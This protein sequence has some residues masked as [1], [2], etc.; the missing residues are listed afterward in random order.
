MAPASDVRKAVDEDIKAAVA[1]KIQ[2]DP[3]LSPEMALKQV[4]EAMLKSNPFIPPQGCPVNDLPSELL[5]HIFYVGTKIQ[6]D[7]MA[8]GEKEDDDYFHDNELDVA[9]DWTDDESEAMDVDKPDR[10][11]GADED[12]HSEC[13]SCGSEDDDDEEYIPEIPFQVLASHVCKHWRDVAVNEPSL[14][15]R[16]R[17]TKD[18]PF[19]APTAYLERS[20]GLPIDIEIHAAADDEETDLYEDEDGNF[21]AVPAGTTPPQ[22]SPPPTPPSSQGSDAVDH[23]KKFL[24]DEEITAAFNL[25]TPHIARWKILEISTS[26][27]ASMFHA[28]THLEQCPPAPI[29]E[30]LQL[31]QYDDDSEGLEDAIFL[32]TE[33]RK[34]L[35][36]F[37]GQ[38]PNLRSAAFWGVHID[39]DASL[40]FLSGLKDLELAYHAS[41]VRPSYATLNAIL[42]ASPELDTLTL[43]GSGPVNDRDTWD[44]FEPLVLPAVT[45]L[46][47]SQH[48]C[49]YISALYRR[50][51]LPVVEALVLDFDG[52][53]YSTFAEQ[54][55]KPAA[56]QSKSLLPRLK[57]LRIE[58]LPCARTHKVEILKQLTNLNSLFVE[59]LDD[60][61]TVFFELLSE[62]AKNGTG[63]ALLPMLEELTIRGVESRDVRSFVDAR[64]KKGKPLLKLSMCTSDD[65]TLKDKDWF[66]K[67]VDFDLYDPSESEIEDFEISDDELSEIESD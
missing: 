42:Q 29:L 22:L 35:L 32:P 1:Q 60:E 59:C 20:K 6:E 19:D 2:E 50:M 30:C 26:K 52:Q 33:F 14:W 36:L 44:S 51:R 54:L 31:Y 53:D 10:S 45:Q 11:N 39:W 5:A 58:G 24:S 27:Y 66:H 25:I 63:D 40:S 67:N 4:S 47:L 65:I 48:D 13:S 21:I 57:F 49:E 17:F 9:E 34:P 55:T 43:R 46:V 56:G 16:I 62:D 23:T 37:Q 7:E 61:E 8:F 15:T 12:S 3:T 64:R 41:D 18:Y 28:L 38:V